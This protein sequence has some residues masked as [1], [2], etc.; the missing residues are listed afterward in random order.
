[1]ESLCLPPAEWAET[2]F[3]Q[4]QLGDRR[5]NRRLISFAAAVAIDPGATTPVQT[6]TWSSCKGAYRFMDCADVHFGALVEPHCR[7]TREKVSTTGRSLVIHDT[8]EI[9]LTHLHRPLEGLG[10]T[11][12]GLRQGF[13]LHTALKID[14]ATQEV[15]G[16]A[17]QILFCRQRKPRRPDGKRETVEQ[18]LKRPR[19]SEVW[20]NLIAQVGAAPAGERLVHVCDRGADNYE[21]YAQAA[22]LGTGWIIRAAQLRRKIRPVPKEGVA[23]SSTTPLETWLSQACFVAGYEVEVVAKAQRPARTATVELRWARIEMP[24]RSP[25]SA[26][27]KA[28]APSAIRMSAVEVVERR[29]PKGAAPLRWVLLTSEDVGTA[30]EARQVAT[31]YARRPLIEDYHKALKS[32]CHVEERQYQSASRLERITAVLCVTA[33]RLLTIRNLSR[34]EP[35]RPAERAAPREWIEML[36]RYTAIHFPKARLDGWTIDEFTRRLAMLGG[37]LGRKGDGLPGWITLSRGATKLLHLLEGR[38]LAR[39]DC[40]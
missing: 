22:L 7:E 5:R 33:V 2:Q 38:A 30:D 14:A 23:D 36:R 15:H 24:R 35:D 3:R 26:W 13:H 8:T 28:Q 12:S 34:T 20:R 19:E 1:M 27:A 39:D 18:S 32:G 29:P 25:M 31:D 6:R 37:F 10:L 17:G 4:C 9:S 11:G 16:L 40:G 21:V